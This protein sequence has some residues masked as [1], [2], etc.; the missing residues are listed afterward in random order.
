MPEAQIVD[1][2][3]KMETGKQQKTA[4]LDRISKVL[5]EVLD[6]ART[7]VQQ[8]GKLTEFYENYFPHLF[9]RPDKARHIVQQIM[10][11]KAFKPSGFLKQRKYPTLKDGLDNGLRLAHYNPVEMVILRIHEMNRYL[12]GAET[13]ARLKEDGLARFVPESLDR[14][15]LPFGWEFVDDPAFKVVATPEV[16]VPE[17]YDKLVAD[18]LLS[19]AKSLG[20]THERLAKLRGARWGE[21]GPGSVI[22]TQFAGP[23]SVIA[24]EVGHQIGDIFGLYDHLI[25][26][27]HTI[28]RV[29]KSGEK[30]GQPVKVDATKAR[31]QIKAELRALADLR[32]EQQDPSDG[33]KKY[34]RKEAEEEAVMLEA[35][36]A[37]PEKMADV[38][39]TV[40]T[41]WKAFLESD[42]RL[43]PLLSINR[44]VVLGTSSTTHKL[45]GVLTLGRWAVPAEV[46]TIINNQLSPGLR[47]S[48]NAFAR[49]TYSGLRFLGNA[50]NQAS[51]SLSAFHALNVSSDAISSSI[52]LG[53][54]QIFRGD[55]A[56]GFKGIMGSPLAPVTKAIGGHTIIKAMR[57]PIDKITDP[58]LKTI[59]ETVIRAGGRPSMDSLY[60]N[61]A[62]EGLMKTFRD[63][64]M[65]TTSEKAA[66]TVKLLPQAMFAGL[67]MTAK[68]IME[69]QV[70]RLKLGVFAMFADDIYRQ[71]N[72]RGWTDD[73]IQRELA[74]AWDNVD[75]RMGQ[76]AYDNLHWNRLL[77]DS[78]MLA[79]RSVGWNLGSIR[80]FGGAIIDTV[81]VKG[82]VERAKAGDDIITR[83][84]AYAVAS[85][86]SYAI[87][88]SILMRLLSGEWPWED[89]DAEG[90]FEK[91]KNYYFPKTGR[92]NPDG[93]PERLSLPHYSK[94]WVAWATR[95]GKTVLNK[96]NPIWATLADIIENEDYFGVEIRDIDDPFH[97]QILDVG[98]HFSQAFIPF[99]VRNF[100]RMR[101]AGEKTGMAT[102]MALSGIA[103]APGYLS[104]S[105]AQLAIQ[106]ALFD[107]VDFGTRTKKQREKSAAR[108][109]AVKGIRSSRKVDLSIFSESEKKRIK[110]D[111]SRTVFQNQYKRLSFEDAV[112]VFA[113][114]NQKESEQV[115]DL[116]A[117]KRMRAQGQ[118]SDVMD[119]YYALKLSHGQTEKRLQADTQYIRNLSFRLGTPRTSLA[120]KREVLDELR[121]NPAFEESRRFIIMAFRHRWLLNDEGKRTGRKVYGSDAYYR[122]VRGLAKFLR[123]EGIE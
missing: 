91:A 60:H 122:N 56:R 123:D 74:S 43:A 49:G 11:S 103:S 29:Y 106:K 15:Y 102:I 19:V 17:A 66:G 21:S 64:N 36:L 52:A 111:A 63:I 105:K 13:M 121:R 93:S 80:E 22:K 46:A 39:P 113:V 107:G 7:L 24:H 70:P 25:S 34:V 31:A 95:P 117:D 5:R 41:V 27:Q 32:Y 26:G 35:W 78:L 23:V 2:I 72:K 90:L 38:A 88:A 87:Q 118:S 76:L 6:R 48:K 69:W 61:H 85:M 108:K 104:K 120:R 33:F 94:D 119:M 79:V 84:Q 58:R 47:S 53:M 99:S 59:V 18:Q 14:S 73:K 42:E 8:Y 71:A 109:D 16:T 77:K 115:F 12:S 55:V 4:A 10:G 3:D 9:E 54:Q 30:K 67:E 28:G 92:L 110:A 100:V 96:L 40:T 57:T 75:N 112:K 65:G 82:Y 83:K 20:V 97:R 98:Q 101:E 86:F 62:V 44:S 68:P 51:L 116:L 1:F 81:N 114:C 50:M 89:D 45:T 37:A